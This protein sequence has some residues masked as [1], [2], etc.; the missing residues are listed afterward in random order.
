MGPRQVVVELEDLARVDARDLDHVVAP[1]AVL[2][3][4]D[5]IPHP[6]PR[7]RDAD[8]VLADLLDEAELPHRLSDALQVEASLRHAA[9][10]SV[11]GSSV[12]SSIRQ[13]FPPLSMSFF[14]SSRQRTTASMISSGPGGQPPP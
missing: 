2:R 3:P 5:C 4:D 9:A 10:A 11:R 12:P 14:M 13:V 8:P 1:E 6:L 7:R